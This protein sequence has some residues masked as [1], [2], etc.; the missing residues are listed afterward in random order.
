MDLILTENKFDSNPYWD[1]P[2]R[3]KG[4]YPYITSDLFDQGGY[5]L[6]PVERM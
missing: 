2:L 4:P 5:D 6:S 1:V 3:M